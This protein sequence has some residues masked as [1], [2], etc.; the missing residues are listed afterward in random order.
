MTKNNTPVHK[1]I[2]ATINGRHVG[3]KTDIKDRSSDDDVCENEISNIDK[4]D[5][6]G[7]Q[8]TFSFKKFHAE[9]KRYEKLTK[10]RSLMVTYSSIV[11]CV[12]LVFV[13]VILVYYVW[14]T[15][16]ISTTVLTTL[17]ATTTVN[18]IGLGYVL[19]KGLFNN[20]EG[21]IELE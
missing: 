18:V 21:R 19:I 9:L 7:Q 14:W 6:Q 17:L 20:G 13:A 16:D 2:D 4:N 8:R 1:R 12:W 15:P 3:F 11:V 5:I 10:Q